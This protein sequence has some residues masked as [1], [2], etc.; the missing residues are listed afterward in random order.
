MYTVL[1]T[2][3]YCLSALNLAHVLMFQSIAKLLH[4]IISR[5]PKDLNNECVCWC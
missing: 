5:D 4:A 3:Y 1:Q 2:I